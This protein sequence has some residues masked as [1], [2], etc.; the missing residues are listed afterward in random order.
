MSQNKYIT[1]SMIMCLVLCGVL[2]FFGT[3]LLKVQAKTIEYTD[4][5]KV[6]HNQQYVPTNPVV[7]P[8]EYTDYLS[9]GYFDNKYITDWSSSYGVNST[10]FYN[11]FFRL[12]TLSIAT[13]GWLFSGEPCTL[14]PGT[15]TFS[16]YLTSNTDVSEQ[17]GMQ[18]IFYDSNNN[19]LL[20]PAFYE[21]RGFN[22]LTFTLT[23]VCS[24]ITCW[25]NH[26][27]TYSQVQILNTEEHI[28]DYFPYLGNFDTTLGS[29]N[30]CHNVEVKGLNHNTLRLYF[31]VPSSYLNQTYSYIKIIYLNDHLVPISGITK[32]SFTTTSNVFVVPNNAYYI[33]FCF[34]YYNYSQ[35]ITDF[36]MYSG[37][38]YSVDYMD[39][40]YD[41]LYDY[42]YD[43]GRNA[44]IDEGYS[45]GYD[46][47]YEDGTSV[48]V[49]TAYNNGYNTGF[50]AGQIDATDRQT[51]SFST[52]IAG[53]FNN[54]GQFLSIEV[55]PGIT[56]AFLIGLPLLLG[57][58]LI[59]LK[60][61]R[62]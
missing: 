43:I 32:T 1:I 29:V 34:A 60:L 8:V 38:S 52:M 20:T 12:S 59:I 57:A 15:Y 16:F 46:A 51:L 47:G 58:F 22:Y 28:T 3:P 35:Q 44:G 53:I 39:D 48:D 41:D 13:D 61:I 9:Y 25:T 56:I 62:G 17:Q 24:T 11:N 30:M 49:D 26:P 14:Y 18:L 4:N 55:F 7:V 5:V 54:M 45:Q 23:Q 37:Y 2:C 21:V 19:E 50:E 40:F 6:R 27:G 31:D 10:D 33:C 42:G 36:H